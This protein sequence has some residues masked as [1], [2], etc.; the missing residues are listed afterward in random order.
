MLIICAKAINIF[1][2]LFLNIVIIKIVPF[3]RSFTHKKY[4]NINKCNDIKIQFVLPLRILLIS[5]P[6]TIVKLYLRK[7]FTQLTELSCEI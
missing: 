5:N 2:N 7:S 3:A 1:F 6:N 4:K